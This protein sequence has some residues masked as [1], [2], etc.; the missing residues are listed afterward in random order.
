MR[1]GEFDPPQMVP[2]NYSLDVIQSEQ[3]MN[4]S[5]TAAKRSFVLL[6]NSNSFLP[7]KAAS[8]PLK[9]LT[10]VGPFAVAVE[11]LYG[12]YSPTP[13]PAATYTVA[14]GLKML[15]SDPQKMQVV[16]GCEYSTPCEKY[17]QSAV[18][19]AVQ[20]ETTLIIVAL[21]I[22]RSLFSRSVDIDNQMNSHF[23]CVENI[24]ILSLDLY[25]FKCS[26]N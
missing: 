11:E 12:D 14:I 13:D 1:L 18:I 5:L 10:L 19:A 22:S 4:L 20:N 24:H 3:H 21:G 2:F 6:K 8:L 15:V 7:L 9:S 26:E 17:N 16:S 25:Q 23:Y